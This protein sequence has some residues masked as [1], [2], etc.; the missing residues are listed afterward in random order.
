MGHGMRPRRLLLRRNEIR[1]SNCF[2]TLH[3]IVVRDK[4]SDIKRDVGSVLVQPFVSRRVQLVVS[5]V[6]AHSEKNLLQYLVE[7]R[8]PKKKYHVQ[9][10]PN[11]ILR[12]CNSLALQW[13]EEQ[14]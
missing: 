2:W 9:T 1:R 7:G 11:T 5:A 8:P 13:E 3:E 10:L 4:G 14:M 6:C 12:N